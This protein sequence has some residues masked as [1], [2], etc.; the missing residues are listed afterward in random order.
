M[1]YRSGHKP[2]LLPVRIE[3]G[4]A[5]HTGMVRSHNEDDILCLELSL[6]QG[7]ESTFPGLYAVADGVGG[8]EDGEIASSLALRMLAESIIGSLILPRLRG[9]LPR[10]NQEFVLQ[11]LT[12][13]V[14]MANNG[15]Y[16]QAKAKGTDMGTTLAIALVLDGTAYIANVGDSRVYLLG[17]GQLR[18]V[19]NDHSVVAGLAAAGVI[20]PED[21]YTHPRRN[22]ITRCLGMGQDIEVDLFTE[23][24]KAGDSLLLCSDGLWEMVRGD[25]IKE[26]IEKSPDPQ[27]ACE[28]LVEVANQKGG[29][30]N[31]SVVA[32]RLNR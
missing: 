23:E 4:R 11:V 24:L 31:I 19:T 12:D 2:P 16:A 1:V 27:A 18:Q 10:L 29:V 32:V 5:S 30:D 17:G 26:V 9:E 7:S 15:V 28:Q 13:G 14:K 3:S 21:I 20:S 6:G 8:H 22:I 25:K